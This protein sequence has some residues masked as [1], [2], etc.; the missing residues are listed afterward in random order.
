MTLGHQKRTDILVFSESDDF[1]R[2][3]VKAKQGGDWPNCKGIFGRNV[4]LVFVDYQHKE[5]SQRPDFFILSVKDWRKV[6][7]KRVDEIQQKNPKRK[8]KI[9]DENVSVFPEQIGP[10][11]KPY[12]GMGIRSSDLIKYRECWDKIEKAIS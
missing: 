7:E 4:F 10:N 6:L 8:I 2:I 1:T 9:T 5:T 12:A 11:G 3:E